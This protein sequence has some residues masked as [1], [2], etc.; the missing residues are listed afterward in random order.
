MTASATSSPVPAAEASRASRLRTAGVLLLAVAVAA[1]AWFGLRKTSDARK[2]ES[3]F[4]YVCAQVLAGDTDA[5]WRMML[6]PAREKYVKF[7]NIMATREDE[8]T[9]EWRRKVGL[10][11]EALGTLTAQ[12]VMSR[13]Y[14][15]FA[16]ECF[17]N[18]RVVRTDVVSEDEALL[19]INLG[20]GNDRQWMAKRVDGVWRLEDPI[21][22]IT[23]SGAYLEQPGQAGR[24]LPI[25]LDGTPAPP[26]PPRPARDPR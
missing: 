25:R 19:F 16:E 24:Q 21:P 22:V 9:R 10:S 18:A 5:P 14:A 15:A 6:P 20:N 11:K 26:P 17:R 7:T 12:E 1:V 2:P 3:L 23:A 13:E 8:P 4:Y